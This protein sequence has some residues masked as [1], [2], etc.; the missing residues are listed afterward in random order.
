MQALGNGIGEGFAMIVLLTIQMNTTPE[1][2]VLIC[3]GIVCVMAIAVV[4][5]IRE[6][7]LKSKQKVNA[8]PKFQSSE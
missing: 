2:S 6:P 5:L 1:S 8:L 4:S 3:G 7:K